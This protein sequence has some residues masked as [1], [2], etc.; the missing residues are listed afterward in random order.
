M[1]PLS[2][3]DSHCLGCGGCCF[4]KLPAPGGGWVTTTIACRFLDIVTRRCKVYH[5]RFKVGEGCLQLTPELIPLLDWLPEECGYRRW[6]K[7]QQS[8]SSGGVKI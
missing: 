4:E 8:D 7:E 5:K 2:D 6:L 3:W 1:E